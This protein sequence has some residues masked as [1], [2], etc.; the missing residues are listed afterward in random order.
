M[1]GRAFQ[2]LIQKAYDAVQGSAT[3]S[4]EVNGFGASA[5]RMLEAEL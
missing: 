3:G 1:S 5:L 4:S 2:R